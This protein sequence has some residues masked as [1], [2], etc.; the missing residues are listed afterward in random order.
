MSNLAQSAIIL[1]AWRPE[2]TVEASVEAG[3]AVHHSA[4]G[5]VRP[6]STQKLREIEDVRAARAVAAWPLAQMQVMVNSE[7]FA[8]VEPRCGRRSPFCGGLEK[9]DAVPIETRLTR[10]LTPFRQLQLEYIIYEY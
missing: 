5:H 9:L 10:I 7:S 4:P 2:L 6:I 3:V 8:L 1:F